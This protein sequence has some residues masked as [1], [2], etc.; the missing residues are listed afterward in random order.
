M[1]KELRLA[2]GAGGAEMLNQLET[3]KGAT[4]VKNATS[5]KRGFF[6]WM[7]EAAS[8]GTFEAAVLV[9]AMQSGSRRPK[10]RLR[11]ATEN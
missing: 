5:R 2:A 9:L 10:P 6:G 1:V 11:L 8:N 4:N 7:L 3:T